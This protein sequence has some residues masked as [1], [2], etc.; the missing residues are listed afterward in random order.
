MDRYHLTPYELGHGFEKRVM[1]AFERNGYDLVKM[2]QW[3]KN[4]DY[5]ADHAPRREYDIVMFNRIDKQFYIMEC[6]AH[7]SPDKCVDQKLVGVFNHKLKNYNGAYAYRVMVSDTDFT[8]RAKDY[9][10][11]NNILLVNGKLLRMMEER[12]A[13]DSRINWAGAAIS[14]L[15]FMID[16]LFKKMR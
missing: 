11:K 5:S 9:A 1:K 13:E 7:F 16:K 14:G 4:Y 12:G 8:R 10:E 2:N 3:K 6:K 15:E